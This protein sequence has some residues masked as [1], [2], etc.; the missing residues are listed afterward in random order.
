VKLSDEKCAAYEVGD[1]PLQAQEAGELASSVPQWT[2]SEKKIEREFEFK[3][4]L[5]AM[6]FVN[7]VANA[8]SAQDHHPDIHISYDRVRLTLSTQKIG[9]LSR[10]DFILAAQIDMLAKYAAA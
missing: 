5:Q 9:G 8:A 7:Q 10:N 4:F 6:I 2:L 3:D 1:V